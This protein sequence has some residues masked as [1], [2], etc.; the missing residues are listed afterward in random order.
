MST[1]PKPMQSA[2]SP[3]APSP[4]AHGR[5]FKRRELQLADGV[6]LVLN[7]DGSIAQLDGDGSQTYAWAPADP[8]WASHAIRFGLYPQDATVPP[9]GRYV[10]GM[11]PPRR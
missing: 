6:R 4:A 3:A 9:T 1:D 11:R 5:R 8:E 2:P 10:E 7:S